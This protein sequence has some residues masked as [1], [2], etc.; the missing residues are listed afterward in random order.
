MLFVATKEKKNQVQ[1]NAMLSSIS[2]LLQKM[3]KEKKLMQILLRL[4]TKS[5]VVSVTIIVWN[6]FNKSRF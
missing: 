6:E 1:H 5:D 2:A 4:G 3:W